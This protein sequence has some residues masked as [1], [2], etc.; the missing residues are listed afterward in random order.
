[1]E[2][3][4]LSCV[5]APPWQP[6]PVDPVPVFPVHDVVPPDAG[7]APAPLFPVPP[8]PVF[9]P[10]TPLP[11]AGGWVAAGTG[12]MAAAPEGSAWMAPLLMAHDTCGELVMNSLTGRE[13]IDTSKITQ[14]DVLWWG[15]SW[16]SESSR[17]HSV[18]VPLG[19]G[20]WSRRL[21]SRSLEIL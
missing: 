20:T 1:M 4:E 5:P 19:L 12:P 8:S 3:P 13:S 17:W 10:L 15:C 21:L 11:G 18:T 6:D 7:G 9:P 2:N 16:P 14:P